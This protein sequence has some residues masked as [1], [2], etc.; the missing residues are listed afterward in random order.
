VGVKEKRRKPAKKGLDAAAPGSEAASEGTPEAAPKAERD[1]EAQGAL[2]SSAATKVGASAGI[3]AAM[4][5]ATLVN[6]LVARHF[7]RWDVTRGGLYTLSDATLATLHELP[8]PVKI[9]LLLPGG[10]PLTLSVSH[11]LDGYR[12]ETSKLDVEIID[13][14]RRAADFLA[15]AQRYGIGADKEEGRLTAAAAAV[16]VRGDR[17]EIIRPQDLVEVDADD[18][19]RRR[20]RLEQAFTSAL[21]AVSSGDHP[22]ACF[23]TGHGEIAS[24]PLREHLTRSGFE[25]AGI[26]PARGGEPNAAGGDPPVALA[27]CTVLI[28]AGP[29][30]RVP[31][32]DVAR[33]VAYLDKGGAALVAV[34]PQPDPG[35]RG[36]V[37]LGL[38]PLLGSFGL[39]LDGDFVFEEDPRLRSPRGRGETFAPLPRPHPVT[40]TLMRLADKGVAPVLT[41]ASS[42]SA[43]GAGSAATTPLLVTSDLAF[44]MVDFFTW[45]KTG[46]PPVPGPADRKGPLTVAF[47]AERPVTDAGA[48]SGHKH[49]ARLVAVGAAGAL[50]DAN[51]Q[52]EDLRGTAL[53]V[54]SAIAWLTAR[55]PILDIPQKPAFTAGLRV[56]DEWL[57]GTFRYVVLYMPL[58]SM[59][60]GVAV[61][62]RRRG[63]KR[64]DAGNKGAS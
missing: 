26:E 61:Y 22:K 13:P 16:V 62:L 58:A 31:A 43:T 47:A 57:A 6:V 37:D 51:W 9:Y 19:L 28:V 60:L 35:D 46:A 23:T 17:R 54:E 34:G 56:S 59:L 15:L 36:F 44:G 3:V 10:E 63:E 49:G 53:F 27:E 25:V 42:L 2:L 8:E 7:K 45:A 20:P 24:L 50:M 4:V 18:D 33:Y 55:P 1:G 39:A 32:E 52:S 11:L 40:Q 38:G 64:G 29:S 41:V 21:R 48:A 30:E 14:D 12:A 5:L